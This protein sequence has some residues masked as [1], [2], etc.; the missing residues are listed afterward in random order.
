MTLEQRVGQLFMVGTPISGLSSQATHLIASRHIGNVFL[1][2]RSTSGSSTVQRTTAAAQ[3]Q[4]ND[5]NT[6]GVAM[7]ISS[8]QEGGYVQALQGSGFDRI[9]TALTQGG[10]STSTLRQRAATWGKQLKSAGV[11][12][13]LAPVADT[14]S[15][16]LGTAN[17][18]IGK[19]QRQYGNSASAAASGSNAFR[20]GMQDSAVVATAKHFPGLGAVTGNTD[21]TAGV[22]DSVTTAS[23]SYLVPFRTSI[24]AGVPAVMVSNAIYSRI[25]GSTPAP[26]SYQVIMKLLRQNEKF[27]GV[28]ISDDLANAKAV[29]AWSYQARALKFLDAGGML[30]LTVNPTATGY[31][32]DTVL[33]RAETDASFR[34]NRVNNA[35]AHILE[36][37]QKQGLLPR[38]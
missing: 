38:C 2:G 22:T 36:L 23:S 31:M 8:D 29:S 4:A 32:Y 9:P 33:K 26:F 7:L 17:Q 15:P 25:D 30:I 12:M 28:V 5:R 6:A 20:Q 16:R 14:V 24:K 1:S 34:Q 37:K 35:V 18:P 21:L 10:W 11:N 19:F 3:S 13:N 27:N